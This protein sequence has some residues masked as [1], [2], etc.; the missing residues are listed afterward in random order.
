MQS[1]PQADGFVVDKLAHNVGTQTNTAS[2]LCM[3]AVRFNRGRG[4]EEESAR[5]VEVR[6][7]NL[8]PLQPK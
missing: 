2:T 3:K 1:Y 5:P 6:F 7:G 8:L 4:R